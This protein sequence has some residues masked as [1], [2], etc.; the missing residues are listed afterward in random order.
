MDTKVSVEKAT[1][2][3]HFYNYLML[4]GVLA[5]FLAGGVAVYEFLGAKR[6]CSLVDGEYQLHLFP[7]P[8]VHYCNGET[9]SKYS[10]GWDFESQRTPNYSLLFPKN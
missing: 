5:V 7:L 1:K 6:F 4:A 8:I 3:E 9:I 2:L 10:D